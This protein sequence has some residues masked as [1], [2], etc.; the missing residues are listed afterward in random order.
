MPKAKSIDDKTPN[1]DPLKIRSLMLD[2]DEY[3]Q[4]FI[5]P[6]IPSEYKD[7]REMIQGAMSNGWH[8]MYRALLTRK[9]ERQKHILAMKIEMAMVEV[10]LKEIRDVCYRGKAGKKLD[11]NARRRFETVANKH[12][13][14]MSIIWAWAKNED[15]KMSTE[16]IEKL[17]GLVEKEPV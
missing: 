4:V 2:L 13:G 1:G 12:R 6:Q 7:F 14:V 10:Y 3:L 8:E 11:Q 9:R 17:A 5:L 15:E 16:N